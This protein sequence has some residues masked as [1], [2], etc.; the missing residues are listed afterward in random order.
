MTQFGM[1]VKIIV[2]GLLT[3]LSLLTLT[4]QSQS[5]CNALLVDQGKFFGSQSSR[6]LEAADQ[7]TRIGAEVRIRTMRQIAPSPT[8]DAYEAR[9]EA[10]CASWRA[11]GGG[12]KNNLLVF[13]IYAASESDRGTGIYY[14]AQWATPLDRNSAYLRIQ[15][16]FMNPRFRD[17]DFV[18]GFVSG[19]NE[20]YRLLSQHL[21]P[22]S[23][24]GSGGISSVLLYIVIIIALLVVLA[25]IFRYLRRRQAERAEQLA[26]QNEAVAERQRVTEVIL[27]LTDRSQGASSLELLEARIQALLRKVSPGDGEPFHERILTLKQ[28]VAALQSSVSDLATSASDPTQPGLSTQAYNGIQRRYA[29]IYE[30]LQAAREE[31]TALK[32]GVEEMR[33]L[34]EE[35]PQRLADAKRKL[36][37]VDQAVSNA[38]K[39][40]FITAELEQ[41]RGSICEILDDASH[42]LELNTYVRAVKL[43]EEADA[44]IAN[45]LQFAKELPEFR[46]RVLEG[47]ESL[48]AKIAETEKA[49]RKGREVFDEIE[50]TFAAA[51]I[52]PVR[53]NGSES[54]RR[55]LFAKDAQVQAR[56]HTAPNQQRWREAGNLIAE[57]SE[58]LADAESMMRSIHALREQLVEARK[59]A[60]QE[61]EAAF[62]D[63]GKAEIFIQQYDPDI[64]EEL[65]V[66]LA[67][68]A[69]VLRSA[70]QMLTE[71]KPDYVAVIEKARQINATADQILNQAQEQHEQSERLRRR[72]EAAL[73]KAHRDISRAKEFIEDHHRD[74]RGKTRKM[75]SEAIELRGRA[76][77]ERNL[78]AALEYANKAALLASNAYAAASDEVE[79][80]LWG[81]DEDSD[82]DSVII[83]G[84]G[85]RRS[86]FGGGF[87]GS[88]SS[89]SSG[90]GFSLGG[91][92]R[93]GGGGGS[94]SWGGGRGGGGS[95]RW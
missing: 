58:R 6:I 26:A 67:N 17:G 11:P 50:E 32:A 60:P 68:A 71:T 4:A 36:T 63:L 3:C 56:N 7:L 22:A 25:W 85:R 21:N 33:K 87:F 30:K 10:E 1:R 91:G 39:Q 74:V 89:G 88:G 53:G 73:S 51:L 20:A 49:I 24:T 8:L 76:M 37:D 31:S 90:G 64:D 15:T 81:W 66:D 55:V 2:V 65:E 23:S 61:I 83:F 41:W 35:A 47:I 77:N 59:L 93:G 27:E 45:L 92:G 72:Y 78:E 19:I 86:S 80:S 18:G 52:E 9:I 16:E 12:R 48:G 70:E 54:E 82:D 14:G 69:D 62:A 5:D 43:A 42:A 34:I 94:S 79:R 95:S 28:S 75:L 84:G 46:Q 44:E 40:G 57:A 29:E 13:M 38:A